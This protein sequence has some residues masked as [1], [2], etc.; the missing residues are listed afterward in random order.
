[1][2]PTS[3]IFIHLQRNYY[4]NSNVN[5]FAHKTCKFVG[6]SSSSILIE[7]EHFHYEKLFA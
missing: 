5:D 3:T 1:M 6:I 4:T 7:N 2:I